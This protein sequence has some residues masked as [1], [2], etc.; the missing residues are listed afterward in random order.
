MGAMGAPKMTEKN[1]ISEQRLQH[2]SMVTK[3]ARTS[4]A[5]EH[6]PDF[7]TMVVKLGSLYHTLH[8]S[9]RQ[10]RL[11][12]LYPG[13]EA[14][15]LELK[16]PFGTFHCQAAQ[17]IPQSHTPEEVRGQAAITVFHT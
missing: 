11:F 9:G 12:E 2:P 1:S 16:V 13:K 6:V 17:R 3:L 5:K 14:S 15:G 8:L 10:I 4:T 7:S